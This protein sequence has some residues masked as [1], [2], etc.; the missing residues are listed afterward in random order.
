MGL[1]A[2]C[3]TCLGFFSLL[4]CLFYITTAIMVLR[5]NLVFLE[6]KAGLNQFTMTQ[7]ELSWKFWEISFASLV[8]FPW[9][10]EHNLINVDDVCKHEL[11]LLASWD[12]PKIRG[13]GLTETRIREDRRGLDYLRHSKIQAHYLCQLMLS[14]RG[15]ATEQTLVCDHLT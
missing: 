15:S 7:N 13:W 4:G 3:C 11:L 1:K 6:H 2:T 5:R 14:K 12:H 9:L 8:S 10:D